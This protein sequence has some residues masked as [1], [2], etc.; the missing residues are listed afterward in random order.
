MSSARWLDGL[1]LNSIGI[2]YASITRDWLINER[3][4]YIANWAA[5][6]PG[7]LR[8][9]DAGCGSA[10]SF[11]YLQQHFGEKVEYYVG[12]DVDTPRLRKRYK[13]TTIKPDF[14]EAYLDSSWTLGTFDLIIASEVI[15]HIVEDRG[16]FSRL[17]QHLAENGLL[18]I[19]TP[20]KRF[21][22]RVASIESRK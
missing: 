3:M 13:H 10:L 1:L 14:I 11:L 12:I 20:N 16:L 6:S 22:N 9:L 17:Y 21:V 15:E 4:R 19:T 8:V 2:P 18:I 7:K 5:R